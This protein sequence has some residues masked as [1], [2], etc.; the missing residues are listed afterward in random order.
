[1]KNTF[2]A[3]T[4]LLLTQSSFAL[5]TLSCNTQMLGKTQYAPKTFTAP[6]LVGQGLNA[7]IRAK[8]NNDHLYLNFNPQ[9]VSQSSAHIIL[10][11]RYKKIM[12]NAHVSVEEKNNSISINIR[13]TQTLKVQSFEFDINSEISVS[14]DNGN[15][16]LELD[17]AAF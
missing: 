2:I 1:M 9:T 13:D 4:L 8:H 14:F 11:G 12:M 7:V 6:T 15:A 16:L 3:A 17:C 5:S 10:D